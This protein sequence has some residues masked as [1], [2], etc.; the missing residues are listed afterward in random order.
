MLTAM[1]ASHL[2][3][4]LLP[5]DAPLLHSHDKLFRD[6]IEL[7]PF[8]FGEA[9]QDILSNAIIC[10]LS[11]FNHFAPKI[12][13]VDRISARFIHVLDDNVSVALGFLHDILQVA[14]VHPKNLR[15]LA[16][17]RPVIL[18]QS[19]E[20]GSLTSL[21]AF[22]TVLTETQSNQLVCFL[23]LS[24]RL[25]CLIHNRAF[26][27][28]G[29]FSIETDRQMVSRGTFYSYIIRGLLFSQVILWVRIIH[30]LR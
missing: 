11:L 15:Q 23:E 24:K 18:K 30:A 19:N 1:A 29:V 8:L 2:V 22:R 12:G 13:K 3:P 25:H 20:Q 7:S 17:L 6:R 27:L 10:F 26:L 14:S 16:L 9:R 4:L 28:G 5:I 21:V